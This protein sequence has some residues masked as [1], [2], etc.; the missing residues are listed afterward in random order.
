M[1]FPATP[2]L[3]GFLA[4]P[5]YAYVGYP[6][7]LRVVSTLRGRRRLATPDPSAADE[8]PSITITVPAYNEEAQI[9]GL[10]ES[11]LKLDY[12]ADRRQILIVSDAST[13]RTDEIVREYADRGVELLRLESRGGKGAAECAAFP[14]LRGEIVVNTDAST[15]IRPDALKPLIA[16]F[17]DPT[18]G[19]ASGRD[20][21]I[22]SA[23]SA[24]TL[25]E[26][27]Y[28][29]YEMWVRRLETELDG[30]V[31][32]SGCFFAIRSGIHKVVLP[33][34]ISRDFAAALVTRKHGFRSVSV[35]EAV[36]YVPRSTSLQREYRRKVRTIARGLQTLFYKRD[37]MNPARYGAFSWMLVSHKLCRWLVPWSMAGAGAVLAYTVASGQGGSAARGLFATGAATTLASLVGWELSRRHELP[38][39]LSVPTF[40]AA[41]NAATIHAWIVAFSGDRNPVWEPTRRDVIEPAA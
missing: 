26:S 9:R 20:I 23:T 32:A 11:L 27:G 33:A 13:D 17:R 39:A 40:I 19:L 22:G 1:T 41:A 7:L 38:R 35:D 6:A 29:G 34:E 15:R 5:A 16:A 24:G 12:P 3:L 25:G 8:W 18:V 28:V 14:Y 21:S 31:G 10:L 4:V 36:C 2:L 37:L 30:I